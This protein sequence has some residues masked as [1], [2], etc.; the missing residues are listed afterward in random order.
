MNIYKI[1]ASLLLGGV[2]VGLF[3][4][5]MPSTSPIL[6]NAITRKLQP[7]TA[8]AL[9]QYTSTG[10]QL[11]TG[12]EATVTSGATSGNVGSWK[13][14]LAQDATSP[15]FN[16]TV[17]NNTSSGLNQQISLDGVALNNANKFEVTI[18]ANAGA[19]GLNRLYQIC[20]WTS[21][22]N[23][24]AA[25]DSQCTGGGWRTLNI[26]KAN[27]TGTSITNYT[28]HIY[29]GYW[30][31][32][33]T[34]NSSVSTPLSNFVTTDSNKRILLRAYS[35][36][37]T[38][39]THIIDWVQVNV[40][41]DPV[42]HAASFTQITG[43]SV[44]TSYINTTNATLTGQSGSDNTRLN[45]P[46]TA[47][48]ISD[49]YLSY[50]NIRTYTGM[51]TIV[52]VSEQSCSTTGINVTPKIYNFTNSSWEN[53]TS[54]IACST[55][56]TI[57]QFAKN[58]ITIGD[59]VSGGEVRVG[60]VGSA[61]NTLSNQIDYQYI[62]LGS[63]NTDSSLCEISFGTG[64][65][66][67]CT[68][69][70]DLDS[71]AGSPSTWQAT[72]E[73]ESTTF[74]HAFYGQDNDADATS[75]EAAMSS[76]L[77]VP[78][79]L[80]S[81]AAVTRVGYAMRW[82]SNSTTVTTQG[83][84]KDS[85]GNNTTISGGWTAFGT[86]NAATTYTYE[87]V[88]TNGY[89]STSPEDYVD[90]TNNRV[91]VRVRTS[92]STNTTSA[93]GDIDFVMAS[94]RWTEDSTGHP[95][96]RSQFVPTGGQL[97]TG[98]ESTITS[99]ATSGNV[100]S[101][102]GTLAQDAT[103][104]GFNWTV[105]ADAVNG[106]NQQVQLDGVSSNGANKLEVIMR[107][108][109][110]VSTISRIYQICDWVSTTSVDNAADSQC[111]GGGWR[112]MNIRKANITGTSIT[113]YTWHIYDG[114]WTT[115]TTGNS[116][117]STPITNFISTD[118]NKRILL[119]AY[120]VSAIVGTH[121]LDWV[122]VNVAVDPVYH[123]AGFTKITG[124]SVATSYINT[125]NATLT[126]QSG[127]DN[128]Y[129]SVPGTA[130]SIADFYNSFFNV[131]TY[132]GMNT[133]VVVSEESC[134]TT[135]INATPK[136]YN[137]NS[138]AWENL[139]SAIACS[140]TDTI[141][142]FAK[143]NI[144]IGDYVSGGEVRVG[145]FG[146]GNNTLS[147]RLDYE[148]IIVGS[149]N[150]DSSLCE[151][152]FG[153][154]TATNCTNT[155]DLD[156]TAGSPSTWQATTELES[157][158]FGHAFYGQDNDADATSVEAAMSSN[159]SVP[160]TLPS[161]AAVT[162]VGY[163]MR[164]R[165]NSTTVTTQGQ[166]KDSSGNNTTI[167]GG[168]TA[169]GTTNAATTYTY[170]DAITNSYFTNSPDDYVDPV[171]NRV[172]VRVRTTTST[173][174]TSAVGDIDFAF[175]SIRWVEAPSSG[176]L[177][178]DIVDSGGSSVS[179]PSVSMGGQTASYNCQ[180]ATGTFGTSSQK[181]R[182]TNDTGNG[183]WAV[184]IAATSGATAKWSTGSSFYDYN[185]SSGSGCSDGADSDSLSGQLTLNPSGATI[186]PKGVCA[187]TGVSVGSNAG[188]VEGTTNN[189]TLMTASSSSQTHCYYDLTGVG[190]SQAI[191]AEQAAGSYTLNLTVTIVA[192]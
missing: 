164:W 134:S 20:D 90:T 39:T 42:Y 101:W 6:D 110:S 144:T 109:A 2:V 187:T 165:S 76:N 118:S 49:F 159:L 100:G 15:G 168:W 181:L 56:D 162:R 11:V 5:P 7:K 182:T 14:T 9:G 19:V 60:W 55:T 153:T 58:N 77:S 128:T 50:K 52:V 69:T 124:G 59:Y 150:T 66:T 145:W 155:R 179:A 80:P 71:T 28:W 136:I 122:Q 87:D 154:G 92:A 158:T 161:G 81:G 174:T 8:H 25:A 70:R 103:S 98:T 115:S 97:V 106:V 23:V 173:N 160:V 3:Y 188:F 143:N 36:S 180:T 44:A 123:P 148:Y 84:F 65:A 16:W 104:P 139:T 190:L 35:T 152:S 189:I 163:A 10:G 121:T 119:R 34:G 169:F 57:R 166:F 43:G 61:N 137:F 170:E 63:T 30:T 105:N 78:V 24:D 94:I 157:T 142:Q 156:S 29:D 62:V 48:A 95:T 85:S 22:S 1:V 54:A 40:I 107:A 185:D 75:V 64:T 96:L 83:Q 167:S 111:T 149:T 112:T 89:F 146:S 93:V 116:T 102:K 178:L 192:N 31:T 38:S 32:S 138:S 37:T 47:G 120:S 129:L 21:S 45:V 67:N 147:I 74:G 171:N 117:V 172:N 127:S 4:F 132:T 26:L 125:T 88:I 191:P 135:G 91:N 99:G 131:K 12:S 72:T 113:N 18:R 13:G 41:V 108:N 86:T 53:L 79:T 141:R 73:L 27:I 133:I 51:N 33:T 130:S 114:Y 17:N 177:S 186:T 184:S 176:T 68:N 183:S 175:V 126:G 151:I 140:T 46:G 82:R